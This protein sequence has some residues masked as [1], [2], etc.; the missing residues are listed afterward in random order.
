M[1][2]NCGICGSGDLH[3]GTDVGQDCRI[4]CNTCEAA[5]SEQENCWVATCEGCQEQTE[6]VWR[7][8][9]WNYCRG[10]HDDACESM[11]AV[12]AAGEV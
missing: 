7:W 4:F 8:G 2:S 10:C 9:G 3:V 12:R 6:D 1:R 5:F 11:T